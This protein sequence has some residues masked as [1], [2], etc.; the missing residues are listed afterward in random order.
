MRL[1]KSKILLRQ[2][3]LLQFYRKMKKVIPETSIF[4]NIETV[5]ISN[6]NF[7]LHCQIV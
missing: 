3:K 1:F 6:I 7:F 5:K 4:S 2:I